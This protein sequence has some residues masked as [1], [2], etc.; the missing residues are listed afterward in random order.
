M[1]TSK[2]NTISLYLWQSGPGQV[3]DFI[4]LPEFGR[5]LPVITGISGNVG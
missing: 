4:I 2:P 5:I 3:V 1:K